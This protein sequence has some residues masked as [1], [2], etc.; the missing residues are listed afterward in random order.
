[1]DKQQQ[2]ST[3]ACVLQLELSLNLAW[4]RIGQVNPLLWRK[5]AER[6]AHLGLGPHYLVNEKLELE[7]RHSPLPHCHVR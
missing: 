7:L 6:V 2:H 1:M 3:G 4:S 5:Q